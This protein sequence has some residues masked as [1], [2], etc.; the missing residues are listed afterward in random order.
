MWTI[1][2]TKVDPLKSKKDSHEPRLVEKR[3][4]SQTGPG[5]TKKGPQKEKTAKRNTRWTKQK[6]FPTNETLLRSIFLASPVGIMFVTA[7]R[8]ISLMND[9]MTAI[10]GYRL[11]DIKDGNPRIFYPTDEEYTRI[12]EL[13][14]EEVRA[15]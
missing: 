9:K 1:I 4:L 3:G 13:I 6:M 5:E 14:G 11:E 7:D 12:T 15:G 2:A 10:T 8:K